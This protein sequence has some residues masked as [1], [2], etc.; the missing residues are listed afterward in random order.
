[1]QQAQFVRFYPMTSH[2]WPCLRVEIFVEIGMLVYLK[3]FFG[4]FRFISMNLRDNRKQ[5]NSIKSAEKLKQMI[6]LF[7][8][9][10]VYYEDPRTKRL[11][12][13]ARLLC[14]VKF[15]VHPCQK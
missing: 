15:P 5:G 6:D 1:M 4:G 2:L 8:L 9:H 13:E 7:Q 14:L 11:F 3:L 10:P 12:K